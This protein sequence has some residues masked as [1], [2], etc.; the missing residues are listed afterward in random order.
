MCE[1]KKRKILK[2]RD[3]QLVMKHSLHWHYKWERL[4]LRLFIQGTRWICV[5]LV[6]ST[7]VQSVSNPFNNTGLRVTPDSFVWGHW[8]IFFSGFAISKGTKLTDPFKCNYNGTPLSIAPLSY[9]VSCC[10]LTV[11]LHLWNSRPVNPSELKHTKGQTEN[12]GSTDLDKIQ[13]SD[14]V[15]EFQCCWYTRRIG[16]GRLCNWMTK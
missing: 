8:Y 11:S 16:T 9:A 2:V 1:E 7:D 3:K 5:H 10:H 14:C 6:F 4:Y 13:F 12:P 15:V